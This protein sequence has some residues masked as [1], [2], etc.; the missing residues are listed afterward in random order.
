MYHNI[1][2]VSPKKFTTGEYYIDW[3]YENQETAQSALFGESAA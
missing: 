1:A 2:G 3:A